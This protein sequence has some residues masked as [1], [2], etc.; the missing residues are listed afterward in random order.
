[1]RKYLMNLRFAA[2]ETQ[3]DV[4]N[5]LNISRQYYALIESGQRQKR[6][7]ITLMSAISSHF[8]IPIDK[9]ADYEANLK[10]NESK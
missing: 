7:D 6:M 4:A 5:A 10:I 3:Q 9:I 8:N 1:M 2:K